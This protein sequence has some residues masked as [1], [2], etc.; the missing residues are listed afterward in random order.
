MQERNESEK[1]SFEYSETR[2][3][4]QVTFN[5]I[6][7][8]L[9]IIGNSLVCAAYH[10]NKTIRTPSNTIVLSMAY[11]DLLMVI[12]FLFKIASAVCEGRIHTFVC[13]GYSSLGYIITS[14]I[15]FHLCA[16]SIDR[17]LAVKYSLRYN[18]MV[19]GVRVS[20]C[21]L[22][23]WLFGLFQIAMIPLVLNS[24][25]IRAILDTTIDACMVFWTRPANNNM[26][27]DNHSTKFQAFSI[28]TILFI[29]LLPILI[30]VISYCYIWKQALNHIKK[31]KSQQQAMNERCEKY[32]QIHLK[33]TQTFAIV[34]G[35]FLIS[36][37]PVF[38]A[39]CKRILFFVPVTEAEASIVVVL[40]HSSVMWNPFI[41]AWRNRVFRRAV[42]RL[43]TRRS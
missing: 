15:I 25:K 9:T 10:L 24:S 18:S 28:C 19:S 16:I 34:I 17:L 23:I 40:A 30:I 13:I 31:I 36:F 26:T 21:L 14:L 7:V 29:Y 27:W 35:I 5:S 11:C 42:K 32:F 4:V 2:Q 8:L 38:V 41:Y 33:S 20:R 43:I 1:N 39:I 3:V 12:S 6:F 22:G 37:L